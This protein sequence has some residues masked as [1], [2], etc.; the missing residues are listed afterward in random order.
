MDRRNTRSN[1]NFAG[2]R[3]RLFLVSILELTGDWR[4]WNA[5]ILPTGARF[6]EI[7]HACSRMISNAFCR[8]GVQGKQGATSRRQFGNFASPTRFG[9][10]H[11]VVFSSFTFWWKGFDCTPVST[12]QDRPAARRLNDTPFCGTRYGRTRSAR[13]CGSVRR[14]RWSA[15]SWLWCASD[16]CA[17]PRGGARTHAAPG[18][19]N[20]RGAKPHFDA[21]STTQ[22]PAGSKVT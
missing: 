14:Y 6:I 19:H 22:L 12:D 21:Y 5:A 17:R 2:P 18:C 1:T 4:G 13:S 16:R 8:F 20:T 15:G 7:S 9:I 11:V 3:R 10:S